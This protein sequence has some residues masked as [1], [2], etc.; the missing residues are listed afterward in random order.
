MI[1]GSANYHPTDP[2]SGDVAFVSSRNISGEAPNTTMGAVFALA[3]A[4]A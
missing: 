4:S 1:E 3:I 2:R